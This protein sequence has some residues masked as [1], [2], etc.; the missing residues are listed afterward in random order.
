MVVIKKIR[1]SEV[2]WSGTRVV[3]EA[4]EPI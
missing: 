3:S 2:R 4:L 1:I